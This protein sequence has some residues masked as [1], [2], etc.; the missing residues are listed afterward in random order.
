MFFRTILKFINQVNVQIDDY[1]HYP[2]TPF[3]KVSN[4]L[5]IEK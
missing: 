3:K 2:E 1:W 4:I 5:Y